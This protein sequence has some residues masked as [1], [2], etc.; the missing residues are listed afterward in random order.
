MDLHGI[1]NETLTASCF[2]DVLCPVEL[3]SG[4]RGP[5]RP[6]VSVTCL[7]WNASPKLQDTRFP[8]TRCQCPPARNAHLVTGILTELLYETLALSS[9]NSGTVFGADM[10]QSNISCFGRLWILIRSGIAVDCCMGGAN[11]VAD[12]REWRARPF[13]KDS[14]GR[15]FGAN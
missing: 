2:C 9:S 11:A 12:L 10:R 5:S 8:F 7:I 3:L 6:S 13:M 1:K 4:E 14:R 15:M